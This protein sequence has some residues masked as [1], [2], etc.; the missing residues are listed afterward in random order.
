MYEI[1]VLAIVIAG[2][3]PLAL[4]FLCLSIIDVLSWLDDYEGTFFRD[5]SVFGCNIGFITGPDTDLKKGLY[6]LK[7]LLALIFSMFLDKRKKYKN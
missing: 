6:L 4:W 1:S 5:C 3:I 7:T 2:G